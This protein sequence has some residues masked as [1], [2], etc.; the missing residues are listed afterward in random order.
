M[1]QPVMMPKAFEGSS[2]SGQRWEWRAQDKALIT[3]LMQQLQLPEL[4]AR[5]LAGRGIECDAALDYLQPTLKSCLPDP[6]HLRDMD[7]AIARLVQA[8]TQDEKIAVF[9]DYDVDGATSS[10]CLIRYFKSIGVELLCHIPDRQKEGYGPNA[11]ALLALQQQGASLVIT[12]DCGAVA[13]APLKAVAAAGLDVIVIDHHKGAAELPEAVAVVN[14]NRLDET[15]DYTHLAAVG[16]VFLTLVALQKTLREAGFFSNRTE[17]NLLHL[18]DVVALG[19][20]CDVVPLTTLNRAFVMQGLKVMQAR[21]NKGLATLID[22]AGVSG[23]LNAYTCG[24]IAGPRINAGGRVGQADLGVKLLTSDAPQEHISISSLLSH[25]NDER[26]AIEIQVQE[27]AFHQASLQHNS[28]MILVHDSG[29]HSGVIGIVASRLKDHFNC[30]AMVLSVTDG[31]GKA[32]ARSVHGVDIGAAIVA[33]REQGIILEGGGHSM[34]GGFSVEEA[35][36]AEAHAFFND[37]MARGISAYQQGRTLKLDAAITIAQAHIDTI[38]LCDR[39]APFGMGNPA[40]RLVVQNATIM[41]VEVLKEQHLKVTIKDN[42]GKT[43]KAMAFRCMQQPLGQ[44]LLHA[45]GKTYHIAGSLKLDYWQGQ[46]QISL[47]IDDMMQ[48]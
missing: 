47:F 15:S 19:T 26:K 36:I 28:S 10:A 43:L 48:S 45:K 8:I 35:K 18:L 1:L 31:I 5:I 6:F 14:P 7:K 38:R 23:A 9:G 21:S 17:P 3:D 33:A 37:F 39:A 24:F 13:F 32:S 44:A 27:A 25:Y 30:P 4:L 40:P 12:V 34:A 16:V 41:H 42:T 46:E 20:I 29:W 22:H 11:P 2:I